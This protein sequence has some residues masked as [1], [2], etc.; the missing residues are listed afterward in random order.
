M[1]YQTLFDVGR[2][3][4][5]AWWFPAFGLFFMAAAGGL[6][7]W[8]SR[9]SFKIGLALAAAWTASAFF[10]TYNDYRTA[11]SKLQN[12]NYAVAEGPVKDFEARPVE[13]W[14]QKAETFLVDGK[15]FEYHG[16]VVTPGFHRMASQG[17]PIHDGLR[18][19]VT[20]SGQDIL[21]LEAAP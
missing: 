1:T 3:G 7:K 2:N 18:V 11:V 13:G 16:A 8:R 17:G 5:T 15:R 19:R 21:R 20:Y 12:G 6:V 4:Y 14:G 10:V 9:A